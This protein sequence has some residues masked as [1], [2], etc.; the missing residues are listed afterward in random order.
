MDR[1]RQGNFPRSAFLVVLLAAG[2][3]PVSVPTPPAPTAPAPPA[4]APV[5]PQD[6]VALAAAL[7]AAERALAE[8][9]LLTPPDDC[10][11]LHFRRALALA[12]DAPQAR[13][14][15]ERIVERYI[16]LANRAIERRNW[17]S[18]RTMLERAA[19]VDAAHPGIAPM[20]RHLALVANAERLT[21][22]LEHGAVRGR[23]AA[24]AR[25]LAAFGGHARRANARVTIRAGSDADGRWIHRQ[26]R[27]APGTAPVRGSIE[28][29]RPPQ[30]VVLL[31]D[32]DGGEG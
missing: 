1:L 10:A 12:P 27:K 29:G 18:A 24:L 4:P 2:C 28:I 11:H 9:R 3:V 23:S 6:N 22:N 5:A 15:M 14:G 25:K 13:L 26:L 19:I 31:F 32:P 8:D 16:V 7:A 30:V 17:G 20:R 21:M